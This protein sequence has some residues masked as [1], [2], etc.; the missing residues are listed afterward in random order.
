MWYAFYAYTFAHVCWDQ[1]W[2]SISIDLT[3]HLNCLSKSLFKFVADKFI[4]SATEKNETSFPKKLAFVVRPS[5]RT[6]GQGTIYL[7]STQNF[8]KNISYPLIRTRSCAYYGVKNVSFSD[9]FA[10]AIN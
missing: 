5:K 8:P 3:N 6:V 1:G 7:E 4:L 2:K 9:N 10:Y